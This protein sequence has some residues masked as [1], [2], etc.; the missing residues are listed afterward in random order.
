MFVALLPV[1]P[2][3]AD[4]RVAWTLSYQG[5]A[6]HSFGDSVGRAGAVENLHATLDFADI[7]RVPGLSF[8]VGGAV[9]SGS[10]PKDVEALQGI[11]N[12][13]VDRQRGR[14]Y[15]LWIEQ[16]SNDSRA[17]VRLGFQEINADFYATDAAGLFINPSFGL[18]AEFSSTGQ[19]GPSTFPS[20]ALALR[21]RWLPTENL[22]LRVGVFNA[23]AN[24]VGD[25]GGPASFDDGVLF[26]AEATWQGRAA[27]SLGG[28]TYSEDQPDIRETD[29]LGEPLLGP[30]TG[31]YA[32]LEGKLWGHEEGRRITGFL[33]AGFADGDTSPIDAGWQAGVLVSNLLEDRPDSALMLGVTGAHTSSSQR[34]NMRDA[35]I[36][37]A[38]GETILEIAFSDRLTPWMRV[39]PDL[40]IVFDPGGNSER[41]IVYVAGLRLA[42]EFA[43]D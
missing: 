18:P 31:V 16:A 2:A 29:A 42:L 10:A 9:T 34:A 15:E 37:P 4:D 32:M 3:S 6:L 25:P 22:D 26:I 14:L 36:D 1:L 38:S 5:D 41:D 27:L 30:S 43:S 23:V 17:S 35:G 11:D 21:G 7:L 20:T 39:Q 13:E 8:H 40:Q 33:R 19:N 12:I 24:S 28:W